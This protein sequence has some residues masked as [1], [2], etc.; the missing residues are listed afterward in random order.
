MTRSEIKETIRSEI[1]EQLS[2][3]LYRFI[4]KKTWVDE[5]FFALT[6]GA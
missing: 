3:L 5:I 1:K 2:I 6:V 4:I